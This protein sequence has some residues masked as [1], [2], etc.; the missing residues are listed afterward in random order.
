MS[1]AYVKFCDWCVKEM[2]GDVCSTHGERPQAIPLDVEGNMPDDWP[3]PCRRCG[4]ARLFG[5]Q[6]DRCKDCFE[7]EN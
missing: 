4:G 3:A 5:D 2:D 7:E 6:T 1:A